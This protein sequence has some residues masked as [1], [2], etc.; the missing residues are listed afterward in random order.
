MIKRFYPILILPSLFLILFALPLSAA[1]NDML[2]FRAGN[3]IIGFAQDKAYLAGMDHALTVQFLGA[4]GAVPVSDKDLSAKTTGKMAQPLGRVTY[5]NL[6]NGINLTYDTAKN[7]ITESTYHIT[8]GAD[9]SDIRL[10]Y[11]VPVEKQ[12]DGS[13]KL[14]FSTGHMIES[15]PIAWQDIDGKRIPVKIAFK[16]SNGEIGFNVGSYD[17]NHPLT[18]DPT[19]SWH[20]FFGSGS[21][22]GSFG[23]AIDG[24]GNI[25]VTGFSNDCWPPSNPPYYCMGHSGGVSDIVIMKLG[26]SGNL[27]W[28]KFYG[29]GNGS[30]G[31]TGYGIAVDSNDNVYVTG[32][33]LGSW[34]SPT[35]AH[36]GNRDIVVI[37]LDS[38]G[39]YQ[40]HTFLGSGY[41][42][43]GY[44]IAIDG[45]DNVYVTGSSSAT[46]G[47]PLNTY[48]GGDDIVILRL[49][50]SNGSLVWHAFIGTETSDV[51]TAVATDSSGNIYITGYSDACWGPTADLCHS[52]NGGYDI[53]VLKLNSEGDYQ[54]RKFFGSASDD[55][56]A[57]IAVSGSY[58]YV[59]GHSSAAW[60]SP[61]HGYKGNDDIVILKL[62]NED[63]DLLWHTFYGSATHDYG[64]GIALDAVGNIYVTG[65]SDAC[66][67]NTLPV[68]CTAHN[69]ANDIFILKLNSEGAK[70]WRN[71]YGS[72]AYDEGYG[73]AADSSGNVYVAGRSDATWGD[74]NRDYSGSSDIVVL[75]VVPSVCSAHPFAIKRT[76]GFTTTTTYY[77]TFTDAYA[78]AN[79]GNPYLPGCSSVLMQANEFSGNFSLTENKSVKLGGGYYECYFWPNN[80]YTTFSGSLTIG[81]SSQAV[82]ID[83]LIIK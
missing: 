32:Y 18:I 38:S 8:P 71:F 42:D 34:G 10:K 61:L 15:A 77:S 59:T 19:Y 25:Y 66:W 26:S 22:D 23:I 75:K 20:A 5:Q 36:S 48:N 69:G 16:V 63:G 56:G 7:G 21:A 30:I 68:P 57:A 83:R 60:G 2:Q 74:P 12:K 43:I 67:G 64:Y 53:F 80:S 79:C 27:Q 24:G 54:W 37:K 35:R 81:A 72:S 17:G 11:N 51:G 50:S 44:G 33:S 49:N 78:A 1:A 73:I 29:S 41:N 39:V 28:R 4:K 70:Q 40:W 58:V 62:H 52:H 55:F 45:S 31:E 82:K 6:W 14:K 13:L 46:W 3:H 9:V 65:K 47:T 76:T